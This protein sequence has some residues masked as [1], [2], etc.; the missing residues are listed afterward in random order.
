MGGLNTSAAGILVCRSAGAGSGLHLPLLADGD[1]AFPHPLGAFSL[2][3][4]LLS[5]RDFSHITLAL[6]PFV[7]P[8]AAK[9]SPRCCIQQP[10]PLFF[11][12]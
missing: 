4:I 8:S 6:H 7:I 10:M 1:M 11:F 12:G 2:P 9:G 3:S 5:D